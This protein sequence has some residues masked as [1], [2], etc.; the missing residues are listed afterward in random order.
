M[1]I[2]LR[3]MLS[4]LLVVTMVL[5]LF[6]TMPITASAASES[7]DNTCEIVGIG[8][9]RTNSLDGAL[10][11]VV[12]GETIKLLVD[13][14]LVNNLHIDN[15]KTFTLDTNGFTLDFD[16]NLLVIDNSADVTFNGCEKFENLYKIDIQDSS[17]KFNGDLEITG[18][19]LYVDD[20][21]S[22]T[23]DGNVSIYISSYGIVA[24]NGA[25]VIIHGDV[26]ADLV[27][28]YAN[29]SAVTVTGT[30]TSLTSDGVKAY[31]GAT[32]IINGDVTADLYGVYAEASAVTVS[33]TVTSLLTGIYIAP[34]YATDG[35][36]VLIG[37]DVIA[38]G[39]DSVY[40]VIC[41]GA[42]VSISG[43]V[44][45]TAI[46]SSLTN[47]SEYIWALAVGIYCDEGSVNVTKSVNASADAYDNRESSSVSS[48]AVGI[49]C[50]G[51]YVTVGADVTATATAESME[52]FYCYAIG[53]NCNSGGFVDVGGDVAA[54]SN[55]DIS[56]IDPEYPWYHMPTIG[57]FCDG[58][59]YNEGYEV[60]PDAP[61]VFIGGDVKSSEI[62][63]AV[64][65]GGQVTIEG[66]ITEYEKYVVVYYGNSMTLATL[67]GHITDYNGDGII[68]DF[69][70]FTIPTTKQGYRTYLYNEEGGGLYE[71]E[72]EEEIDNGTVWVKDEIT[73]TG[74]PLLALTVG[75][76]AT[77]VDDYV[78][79]GIMP[80]TATLT[81]LYPEITLDWDVATATGSILIA[82]GLPAGTYVV[83]ITATN[84][85]GIAT[86][87]FTLTVNTVPTPGGP[88]GPAPITVSYNAN[89]GTGT[90]ATDTIANSGDD[91]T[92]KVNAFIR[93]GYTFNGWNT[94]ADGTGTAY[95]PV[96]VI[97]EVKQ[98]ITL[99]A[100]WLAKPTLPKDPVRYIYGYPDGSVRPERAVT[101]AE[102]V[103]I[104]YRLL[105]AADKNTVY[106][107]TFTDVK[108]NAW[109]TQ[110]IAY[111]EK[112]G[113]IID[114]K[115]G[116]FRPNDP[117]T[118][119]EYAALAA[120]FDNL[121]PSAPNIFPDVADDHWA[122]GYINS[123]AD[124]GWVAGF[125]DGTFKPDETLTRAQLVTIINRMLNRKLAAEDVPADVIV[126]TD[127]PETHWA[128]LD[129][130]EASLD[131]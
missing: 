94:K 51:G 22:V 78:A 67:S 27:G 115:D 88:G 3:K 34:V 59:F 77:S 26:T 2:K 100:Q 35:A 95:A 6:M 61:Q 58:A 92:I 16:G 56:A 116:K 40:G 53:V 96:A 31:N 126:Y 1:R 32:V 48:N 120:G 63:A 107:S 80:I 108:A 101:R 87:T 55:T 118:R 117:I 130:I 10:G 25:T 85:A 90:M 74:T 5:S 91:Y 44:T 76:G 60:N 49:D 106:T 68:L 18:E 86:L 41:R 14:T 7:D 124:K 12:D 81:S 54:S 29:D 114:S 52:K 103:M 38:I 112:H 30:V 19:C 89:G 113:L 122:V 39:T 66:E 72:P 75:Y 69:G 36:D 47:E 15:G 128:Y 125:P 42:D 50:R 28:I 105:V 9:S 111:F 20:G 104:F 121:S 33:G 46:A 24:Y 119:A 98:S 110:A 64:R 123:A 13:I 62:G 79:T 11:E 43:N 4:T 131:R 127:L 99:Y 83:T 73:L 82:A 65:N 23:V 70:D 129:I 21:A 8:P 93:N 45:A 97:K 109:Y 17:A 57:V 37:N 71:N 84:A 102:A